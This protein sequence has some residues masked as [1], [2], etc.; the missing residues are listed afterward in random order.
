MENLTRSNETHSPTN[1][2]L[3]LALLPLGIALNLSLGTLVHTIKAPI[4]VDA[5][6]TILVTLLAGMRAGIIVGVVSFIVGGIFV[7][8]VLPW[9]SGTQAAIAI[10][11]YFAAKKGAFRT[12]KLVIVTGVGLGIVAGV[13]SAPVITAL[14]AG[15]TGSGASLIVAFL[16]ASG[17][18]VLQSVVL[19]GLAAEPLDKTI[20]CLLAV[21]LLRGIPQTLLDR[22]HNEALFR[23]G[24]LRGANETV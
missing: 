18:S 19:S 11:T 13:V 17:K 2:Q 24:F 20:Q 15:I 1:P 23:N 9:F 16:L 4:Y 3:V 10:Y 12:Y 6:G 8:P 7:N 21:W 5:V 22:F 14:F